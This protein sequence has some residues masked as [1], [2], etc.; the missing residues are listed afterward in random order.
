MNPFPGPR[1][2][3]ILN[4]ASCHR[5]QELKDICNKAGVVLKFLPFYSPDFNLIKESFLVLKAWVRK[6]RQL[7]EGFEDFSDFLKLAIKDFIKEKDARGYFR[8]ARIRF[9]S[10]DKDKSEASV[11]L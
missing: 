3:L 10:E 4:N 1:L 11:W 8:L 5:S 9:I 7:E 6:I 2:V